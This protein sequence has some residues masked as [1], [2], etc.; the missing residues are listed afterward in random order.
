MHLLPSYTSTA[1]LCFLC[2][3]NGTKW[4]EHKCPG[5]ALPALCAFPTCRVV[6]WSEKGELKKVV[7]ML[8]TI[9]VTYFSR[10]ESAC[11][12]SLVLLQ[13]CSTNHSRVRGSS[14]ETGVPH[15]TLSWSQQCSDTGALHLQPTPEQSQSCSWFGVLAQSTA[16]GG[17]KPQCLGG[18]QEQDGEH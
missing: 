3:V 15:F 12:L 11:F 5:S 14:P 17:R 6:L 18:R 10:M 16:G 9:S 4:E 8:M 13:A 7:T 1:P 2:T